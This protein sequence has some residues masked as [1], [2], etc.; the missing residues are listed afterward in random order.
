MVCLDDM[1][2]WKDAPASSLLAERFSCNSNEG[3]LEVRTSGALGDANLVKFR[4]LICVIE[5]G[6]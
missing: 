5:T 2:D 1:A 6:N 3:L 4:M